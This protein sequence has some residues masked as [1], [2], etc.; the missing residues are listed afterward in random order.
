[1]LEAPCIGVVPS[2]VSDTRQPLPALLQEQHAIHY[3]DFSYILRAP[4]AGALSHFNKDMIDLLVV[5]A[6]LSDTLVMTLLVSL[7]SRLSP[8][9]T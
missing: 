5:N 7:Q 8:H 3:G 6:A 9:A 2:D 1:N 4:T